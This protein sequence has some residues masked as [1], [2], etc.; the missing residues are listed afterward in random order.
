MNNKT[1]TLLAGWSARHEPD[2][3]RRRR[4]E[5]RILRA[6]RSRPRVRPAGPR[7]AERGH[8]LFGSPPA[9]PPPV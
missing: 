1:D 8:P 5:E 2:G 7:R 6:Y 4:L 3:D 9:R